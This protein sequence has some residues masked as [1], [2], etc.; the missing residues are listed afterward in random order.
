MKSFLKLTF[1]VSLISAFAFTQD[2]SSNVAQPQSS[3][4][5]V[6]FVY[7]ATG[8]NSDYQTEAYSVAANGKLTAVEG[9]PFPQADNINSMTTTDKK[10]LFSTDTTYIYSFQI[11]ANGAPTQVAS[12]NAEQYNSSDTG[13]PLSL[14][15]D[16]TGANLYD[17]DIYSYDGNNQYQSFSLDRQDGVLTFLGLDSV[18]SAGFSGPL[19]FVANNQYGYGSDCIY[20]NQV[21][22]G[23]S[24]SS[25][26]GNLVDLNLSPAI[27]VPP[28]SE[29]EYCPALAAAD[30]GNDV[31]ISLTPNND[32]AQTGPPQIGVYTADSSG[33][34]ATNS[35]P[36]NMPASVV[37]NVTALAANPAG[38][39]LAVGGTS[40]LQIFHFNGA[41]P[42]THYTGALT[43]ADI[44]FTQVAWDNAD[45]VYALS[46]G[47]N[48]QL[49]V[50]TVT[51][52]S[53]KPAPGSPYSIPNA[54][55]IGVLPI[56]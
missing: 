25:D 35:T 52:T 10:W 36:E 46:G 18:Y 39:L 42:V 2:S 38:N 48:G 19:S 14:F 13:G 16:R 50:F 17:W 8:D 15:P 41:N 49:Y 26:D 20:G 30:N 24:R 28:K 54:S 53:V 9:S 7:V 31:A 33:N 1:F 40:G 23:F 55:S 3:G 34:L 43:T 5:P 37:S 29:G 32:F 27:P 4:T 44:T 47:T 6:A 21:I 12:I 11:A 56:R 51:P 45:H 22:Y